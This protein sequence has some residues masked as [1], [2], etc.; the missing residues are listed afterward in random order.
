MNNT[1]IIISLVCSTT[2]F[3]SGK[4]KSC[5]LKD[6]KRLEMNL[7]SSNVANVNTTSTRKG[8]PYKRK[9]LVCNKI[10]ACEISES[11][12]ITIKYIP[13]HP[14]AHATGYVAFPAVDVDVEMKKLIAVQRDY[15]QLSQACSNQ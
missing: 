1:L 11:K 6:I 9:E 2:V 7:I 13:D 4:T 5:I 12:E 10:G 15:E 3:A 8:G 14:D